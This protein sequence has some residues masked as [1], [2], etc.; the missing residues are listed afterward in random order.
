MTQN[1]IAE[2][3]SDQGHLEEAERLFEGVRETT[4]QAG[5]RMFAFLA[6]LNLG[7]AAARRR[8]FDEADTLLAEA[9]EGFSEI[10]A[11]SFEQEARA[12]IAEA[13]VLAGDS[14]RALREADLAERVGE[15]PPPLLRAVL[16]RVRGCAHLLA[17]RVEQGAA[18]LDLGLDEARGVG[19]LY[20]I[21]LI[22]EVRVRLAG[23]EGDSAERQEILDA[24]QI[25]RTA[26]VPLS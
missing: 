6:Q 12:R 16:H 25:E 26:Q 7:R 20:E 14:V 5:Q 3:L 11:A 9:L 13:A 22:L 1:N 24:L 10:H 17:G 15:A 4:E 2:I 21:A 8:R 18:E 19:A 23:H